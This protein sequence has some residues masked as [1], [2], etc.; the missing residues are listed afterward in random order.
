MGVEM[1]IT[2]IGLGLFTIAALALALVLGIY[3]FKFGGYLS[4]DQG[5]WGTFGDFVGGTL[6]PLLAFASL[7]AIL[8]TM[9][10]QSDELKTSTNALR[11]Q[12]EYLELQAIENTF[13]SMLEVYNKKVNSLELNEDV[14]RKV[15]GSAYDMLNRA[16]DGDRIKFEGGDELK[17]VQHAYKRFYSKNKPV[18]QPVMTLLNQIIEYIE[19]SESPVSVVSY[20][21]ILKSVMNENEV[22]L[23]FYHSISFDGLDSLRRLNGV[24]MFSDINKSK[25]FNPNSHKKFLEL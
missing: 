11:Q 18:I 20:S 16:Y 15:F 7:C 2:R 19:K 5:V 10:M 21:D 8:L 4:S 23:L 17:I 6:N 24:G 1:T 12:G 14:G 22:L 3:F 25:L 9:K 13:F